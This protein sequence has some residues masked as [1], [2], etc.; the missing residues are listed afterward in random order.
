MNAFIHPYL[1]FY[2]VFTSLKTIYLLITFILIY[3]LEVQILE[4]P[5]VHIILYCIFYPFKKN[6]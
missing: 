2:V 3:I 1:A 5:I 4:I 6:I